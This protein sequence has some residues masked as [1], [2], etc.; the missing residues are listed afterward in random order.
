MCAANSCGINLRLS[1]LSPYYTF[2]KV[3]DYISKWR[4][5]LF[6]QRAYMTTIYENMVKSMGACVNSFQDEGM[7]ILF[8][9]QAPD[10][11]QDYCYVIDVLP[12]NGKI[13]PGQVAE[14]DGTRYMITAVG[15]LVEK[16]L[17]NFGHVTFSFTGDTQ[18]E[19]PG[20][21]YLG[22]KPV[23]QL[24]IGSQITIHS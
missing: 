23:P 1:L 17:G 2:S 19:L 21:I 13:E 12:I 7:F 11:L 8:G 6:W 14:I 10:T 15:E 3:L 5:A 24:N 4:E 22:K 9:N 16:K 20:T 18:A